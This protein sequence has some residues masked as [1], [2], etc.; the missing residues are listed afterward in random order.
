MDLANIY[1]RPHKAGLADQCPSSMLRNPNFIPKTVVGVRANL[2]TAAA[3]LF[4]NVITKGLK[5]TDELIDDY[6][7]KHNVAVDGFEGLAWRAKRL[8]SK[9][10]KML[11][12]G[13]LEQPVAEETFTSIL[14]N[15]YTY[16][17]RPDLYEIHG[18]WAVIVELKMGEVDTGWDL[19]SRDYALAMIRSAMADG[20]K[21]FYCIVLA[22]IADYYSVK[23]YTIDE[24]KDFEKKLIANM[25][26]AGT[27]YVT[28]PLCQYCDNLL[29][30]PQIKRSIDPISQSIMKVKPNN[31]TITG[32]E[33]QQWRPVIK[34]MK[35]ICKVYE[36]TEALLLDR[37]GTI[38]LGDGTELYYREQNKKEI[39]IQG[40]I[41]VM[42]DDFGVKKEDFI[43]R[44]SIGT[45]DIEAL[46]ASTAP[47][48]KK[49]AQLKAVWEEMKEKD[50]M[51]LKLE[52]V[53]AVRKITQQKEIQE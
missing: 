39:D 47:P 7:N 2:G 46:S 20:I 36:D 51:K 15:K 19:Q 1:Y 49:A 44:L 41:S 34:A 17:Y 14:A 18:S 26:K 10:Q 24:L 52:R 22:P 23:S 40:A 29:N 27:D 38:P 48:R 35:K 31:I 25:N 9:Y 13:F 12:K 45:G 42:C 53:R 37:M 16:T 21:K 8:D 3:D 30:C 43:S 4:G 6:A 32:E 28:G 11:E 50:V 5:L 33:I